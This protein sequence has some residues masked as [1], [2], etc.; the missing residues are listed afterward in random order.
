ML[1]LIDLDDPRYAA[2]AAK[3]LRRHDNYE[4]EA[5]ITSAIRDFLIVTGL[6]EKR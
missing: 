3:M 6:A 1:D 5:N 4:V 2:A